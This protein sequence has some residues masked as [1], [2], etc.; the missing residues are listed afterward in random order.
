[1]LMAELSTCVKY[2]LP[3]KIVVSKN[4]TL[5]QIKWEQMVMLG[6]PEYGCDLQPIDFAPRSIPPHPVSADAIVG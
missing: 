4:D 1:M 5:G 3:V 6:N 2:R